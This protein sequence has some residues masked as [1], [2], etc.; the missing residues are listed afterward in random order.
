MDDRDPTTLMVA[1]AAAGDE[2]AWHEI[3]DRHAGAPARHRELLRLLM[4]DPPL[5]DAQISRHP[6]I[7]ADQ[8]RQIWGA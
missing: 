3:V 8:A 4:A 6:G 2:Y 7:L 1:A 5:R